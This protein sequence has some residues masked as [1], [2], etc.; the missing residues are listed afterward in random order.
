MTKII[1]LTKNVKNILTKIKM[2]VKIDL[3]KR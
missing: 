3:S 2:R 1:F